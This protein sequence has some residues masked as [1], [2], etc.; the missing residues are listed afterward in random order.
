MPSRVRRGWPGYN[1]VLVGRAD[2]LF[3]LDVLD[4][5][6]EELESVN[7]G[8]GTNTLYQ[9]LSLAFLPMLL[10][11]RVRT[12]GIGLPPEAYTAIISPIHVNC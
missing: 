3:S 7:D 1:G 6:D 8:K 4:E 5:W 11:R 12:L 2:L 9:P 10:W